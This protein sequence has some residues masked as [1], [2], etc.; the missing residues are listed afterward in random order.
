VIAGR[1]VAYRE[2]IGEFLYLEEL[3]Q[4]QG[5]GEGVFERIREYIYVG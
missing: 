1:I 3:M 5:I 2:E 4:V